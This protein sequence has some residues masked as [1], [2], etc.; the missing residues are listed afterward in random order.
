[1]CYPDNNTITNY[2]TATGTE[3][4]SIGNSSGV[5]TLNIGNTGS[6]SSIA[7]LVGTG[8]FTLDGVGASK[9]DIGKSSPVLGVVYKLVMR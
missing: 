8:N 4:I 6:T 7:M 3:A 9:Y 1:M 2:R 5:N